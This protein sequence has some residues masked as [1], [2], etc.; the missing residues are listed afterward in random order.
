[1][2]P[3]WHPPPHWAEHPVPSV[4][5][6]AHCSLM[7]HSRAGRRR[8][9]MQG[10]LAPAPPC[11]LGPNVNTLPWGTLPTPAAP[12]TVPHP[13]SYLHVVKIA[14]SLCPSGVLGPTAWRHQGHTPPAASAKHLLQGRSPPT[15]TP[16]SPPDGAGEVLVVFAGPQAHLPL[17]GREGKYRSAQDARGP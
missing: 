13:P 5:S 7:P 17:L 6:R 12:S 4:P 11:T 16:G 1:M 3:L 2:T 9:T 15:A 8:A 14:P 10:S